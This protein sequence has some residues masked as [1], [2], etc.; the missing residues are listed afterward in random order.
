MIM[1]PALVLYK[2]LEIRI[3]PHEKSKFPECA[4]STNVQYFG[5][6]FL[7]HNQSGVSPAK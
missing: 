2:I 4:I 5:K 7:S 3:Y 6:P 1:V